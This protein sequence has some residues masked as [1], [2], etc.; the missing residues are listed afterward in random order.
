MAT[1]SPV[2]LDTNGANRR[3]GISWVVLC[4]GLALHVTDEALTGFL[5][6]YNPTA[7]EIARRYGFGPPTFGFGEWLGGLIFAVCVLSALSPF[8]FRNSRAWRPI[9]YI[10]AVIM[11]ANGISHTVGTILGHSFSDIRFPRPMPGFYSSP[12]IFAAGL[13]LFWNLRL[14]ARRSSSNV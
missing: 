7:R 13:W 6:V 4:F 9:G 8:A 12:F 5:S 10:F 14:M 3:L 2:R 11:L 1:A